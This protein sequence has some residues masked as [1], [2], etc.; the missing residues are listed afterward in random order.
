MKEEGGQERKEGK[1]CS[2]VQGG[3]PNFRDRS[4]RKE[5]GTRHKELFLRAVRGAILEVQY[6]EG[7][8]EKER[9]R[10][11]RKKDEE[12]EEKGDAE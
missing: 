4:E 1:G 11:E 3:R 6:G 8:K 12:N 9:K 10:R 7:K 2:F 5:Q